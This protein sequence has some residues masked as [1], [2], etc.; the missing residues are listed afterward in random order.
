MFDGN[1]VVFVW[2]NGWSEIGVV[3]V[4]SCVCNLY[5]D[6]VVLVCDF[7]INVDVCSDICESCFF[8]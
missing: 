4:L 6:G 8:D 3:F 2:W 5:W 1:E 7:V